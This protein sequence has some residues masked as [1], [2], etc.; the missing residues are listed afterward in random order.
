MCASLDSPSEVP[1]GYHFASYSE[2]T[3]SPTVVASVWQMAP[4]SITGVGAGV[5]SGGG[6]GVTSTRTIC[7]VGCTGTGCAGASVGVGVSDA[8]WVAAD[9]VPVRIIGAA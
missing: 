5:G 9:T 4:M 7:G 1:L 6:G 8:I 3:L 2:Y